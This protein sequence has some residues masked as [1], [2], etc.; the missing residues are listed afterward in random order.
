MSPP[1]HLRDLVPDDYLD[2]ERYPLLAQQMA[3]ALE[4][5]D[6]PP[7]V[8]LVGVTV[9][10]S[11]ANR[12]DDPDW[13]GG[14]IFPSVKPVLMR[15]TGLA[16]STIREAYE[17]LEEHGVLAKVYD[18]DKVRKRGHVPVREVG[19]TGLLNSRRQAASIG[20][21][22]VADDSPGSRRDDADMSPG[23]RR[24]AATTPDPGPRSTDPGPSGSSNAHASLDGGGGGARARAREAPP[25][26]KE[27]DNDRI[28]GE[29]IVAEDCFLP[30]L[31]AENAPPRPSM[32]DL[33]RWADDVGW[34]P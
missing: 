22:E 14:S 32:D 30:P 31:A 16:D 21:D 34:Q 8:R 9:A 28:E 12:A 6:A 4:L 7:N 27:N 19:W 23:N 33:E 17:W 13:P 26:E 1:E 18:G 11:Y 25:D 3:R 2:A 10:M 24:A 29:E 5:L 15:V 20:D